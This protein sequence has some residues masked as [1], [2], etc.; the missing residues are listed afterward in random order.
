[1]STTSD[2]EETSRATVERVVGEEDT[3]IAMGSGDLPVLATPRLAAWLE[4]AALDAL[5][6]IMKAGHTSLGVRLDIRHE[7]A[8]PLGSKVWVRAVLTRHKGPLVF[9]AI[10][11]EDE[12]GVIARGEHQRV[13]VKKETFMNH[14]PKL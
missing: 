11:A 1:M 2:N 8:S 7:E 14:L 6:G 10:H 12:R 9:F 3:A 5:S 4:Q 13:I